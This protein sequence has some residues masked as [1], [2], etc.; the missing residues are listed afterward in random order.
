MSA[1]HFEM[2][3]YESEGDDKSAKRFSDEIV[4]S[5][6]IVSFL[7]LCNITGLLSLVAVD[8]FVVVQLVYQKYKDSSFGQNLIMAGTSRPTKMPENFRLFRQC[9]NFLNS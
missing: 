6:E 7:R 1:S 3:M 2:D 5:L 4:A 9:P 8:W